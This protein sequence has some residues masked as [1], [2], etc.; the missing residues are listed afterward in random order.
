[1]PKLWLIRHGETEWS[2]SGRHTGRTD[3]ALSPRGERQGERLRQR[4]AG[5]AFAAVWSSPL[6]RAR[7][8]CRIVGLGEGALTDDDLSEWNYGDYEGRTTAEIRKGAPGWTIW[9]AA[10]AG[11]ESVD[12]VGARTDRV[13]ARA[14]A[15]EGDVALFAHAHLLRVLAARWLGLAA[16]AG[17]CFALQTA[18]VSVLGHEREQRVIE[19]WN[20][21]SHLVGSD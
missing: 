6:R 20:D 19:L 18:S 4:L 5:Q 13:I 7:D 9:D 17:R 10:V 11:G 2:A 15:A 21:A 14:L 1:M 8:T 3:V 12:E 16:V